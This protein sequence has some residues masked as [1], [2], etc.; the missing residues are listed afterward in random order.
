MRWGEKPKGAAL[1]DSGRQEGKPRLRGG[2]TN[3]RF[4]FDSLGGGDDSGSNEDGR[5]SY[6]DRLIR[7]R[8][9]LGLGMISI[10]MLF[11]ALSSA[12]LIRQHAVVTTGGEALP[13]W[14]KLHLPVLM[15]F[16]TIL[17]LISSVTLE[18]ARRQLQRRALFE[19][20]SDIP[21]IRREEAQSLSWLAVT[22]ALGT[23][24]LLGQVI[25]WRSLRQQILF[26]PGGTSS[27]FFYLLTGIHA[28]HLSVGLL[29]LFFALF[30]ELFH[31]KLETRCLIVDVTSWYWHFMAVLWICIYAMMRLSG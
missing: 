6:R 23:G 29:V 28:L 17:L 7:F 19:P 2:G 20:L 8:L 18:L 25:A 31:G 13:H 30:N 9:G 1:P 21:G 11:V 27:S 16:N 3:D 5:L 14:Q 10:F 22:A 4:P 15:I 12:Y 26:L 24:F